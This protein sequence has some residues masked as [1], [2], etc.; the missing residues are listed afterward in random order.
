MEA[1]VAVSIFVVDWLLSLVYYLVAATRLIEIVTPESRG[2][3]SKLLL[4]FGAA[5]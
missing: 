2:I 3:F 1:F 4:L 5:K